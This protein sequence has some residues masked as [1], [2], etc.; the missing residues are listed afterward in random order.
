MSGGKWVWIGAGV[1]AL[2]LLFRKNIKRKFIS[3][4]NQLEINKLHPE[5]RP[6]ASGFIAH[7]ER[8]GFEP[9]ITSGYR[10]HEEQQQLWE[11]DNR[12]A[13]SGYSQHNYGTA[14]DINTE[15]PRL[16]KASTRAEWLPVY[17]IAQSYGLLWGGDF[18]Y[19][20]DPVHFFM[21]QPFTTA[22]LLERYNLGQVTDGFVNLA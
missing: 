21:D 18:T 7:L 15:A 17:Y 2:S 4:S 1:L 3:V 16:R 11:E 5:F 9:T 13:K 14:I 22:Q 10:S 20:Y 6:I 19:Y 8:E 12:N